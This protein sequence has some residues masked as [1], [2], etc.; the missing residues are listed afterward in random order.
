MTCLHIT[1]EQKEGQGFI[2]NSDNMRRED[3]KH[4]E[5][6]FANKLEEAFGEVLKALSSGIFN[7]ELKQAEP[8]K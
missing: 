7:Y 1:I 8:P 6:I 3:A 4:D 2:V 5:I